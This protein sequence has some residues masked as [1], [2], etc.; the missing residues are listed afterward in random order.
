[1]DEVNKK[2]VDCILE[3]LDGDSLTTE[4]RILWAQKLCFPEVIEMVID[5][6][7]SRSELL[8]SHDSNYA[9]EFCRHQIVDTALSK[10]MNLLVE[11]LEDLKIVL[12]NNNLIEKMM[13]EKDPK[14]KLVFSEWL[15][16]NN[17]QEAFVPSDELIKGF[18]EIVV[19]E[20][21]AVFANELKRPSL[22]IRNEDE[23]FSWIDSQEC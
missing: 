14:F 23:I 8:Q 4:Q 6:L 1:M 18:T 16:T 5:K 9:F 3:N 12:M 15:E 7:C 2:I 21:R 11:C 22:K 19:K 10:K 13:L 17:M 20:I